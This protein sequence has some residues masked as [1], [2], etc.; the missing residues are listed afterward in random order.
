MYL[1]MFGLQEKPFHITPNP[2][3]IFLSKNH[4]EAFAHLLY[5]VQQRV[6]FMA[7]VGEVGTG[8]TTVLRTLLQQLE[9]SDCRVALVFNPCLSSLELLQTIHREFG[10]PFNPAEGNLARLHDSLNRFLL[11]QRQAGQ[12]VVLVIDEA[13]NLDPTV[14]EQ[15]RLL[16]NLETETDK[17]LQLI[18][19]GQPELGQML[20]R[21]ELRQLK[22]RLVVRYRLTTMDA[23]DTSTYI[24]HRLRV[25][26]HR[27]TA[28]FSAAALKQ[29]YALTRGLPRLINIL[30]DRALLVAYTREENSVDRRCIDEARAELAGEPL[31][32]RIRPVFALLLILALLAGGTWLFYRELAPEMRSQTAMAPVPIPTRPDSEPPAAEAAKAPESPPAAAPVRVDPKLVDS[33]KQ[34]IGEIG[35]AESARQAASAVLQLWGRAELSDF[36]PG[37]FRP[38]EAAVR[39][40]N[41]SAIRFVG[42]RRQLL[43]L[44]T[45][46][47]LTLVLPNQQGK[48]YLALLKVK[49]QE[50]LIQPALSE[51]G[52]LPLAYLDH[53]WFG[54]AVIP[55]S[56]FE[57][58]PFLD[59]PGATGDGVRR[60]Q[61]LLSMAGY[62]QLQPTG[63]YDAET[64]AAVSDL[65]KRTGLAPDGR[66]GAQ[67]LL[68]IYRLIG[69]QMPQISEEVTQ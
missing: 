8:K 9:D 30:C 19:V 10:I 66:I 18:I 32:P 20:E 68:E 27:G 47:I 15:L 3:F 23:E 54:K 46:A 1:K 64:I 26:G 12:T 55:W 24:R 67:T 6:G 41:L 13:Q 7:L 45:P 50:V 25:A 31:R 42:S 65:Q 62:P 44:D 61:E 59:S 22:Q 38:M 39:S 21:H 53:L 58:L 35:E 40:R 56:N 17:L 2:R 34:R 63:M 4:K 5:G 28:L 69:L 33:L 51:D 36:D 14:L 57:K 43:E 60:T 29:I 52:W 48:R 16:S 37:V 11:E 49:G